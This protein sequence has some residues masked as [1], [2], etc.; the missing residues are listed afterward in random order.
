MF[1]TSRFR[2]IASTVLFCTVTLGVA[3]ACFTFGLAEEVSA[4]HDR[5]V[6]EL[7]ASPPK[8]FT[9]V[10]PGTPAP[11]PAVSATATQPPRQLRYA[12]AAP[13]AASFDQAKFTTT[14]SLTITGGLPEGINVK[15]SGPNCGSTAGEEYSV[16]GLQRFD[17]SSF[18]STFIWQHPHPPCALTTNHSDVTVVATIAEGGTVTEAG[19]STTPRLVT[20]CTY[21]G[22]DTGTG[23]PCQTTQPPR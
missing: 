15:W 12:T 9:S 4:D 22:S 13:I 14:Y 19:E 2:R 6:R 3:N 10:T 18:T 1:G 20:I 5:Q 11:P 16:L 8:T 17:D 21:R 7:E 23:Q